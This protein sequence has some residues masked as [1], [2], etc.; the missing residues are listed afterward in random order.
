M[1]PS[2]PLLEVLSPPVDDFSPIT[3]GDPVLVDVF[4]A[5]RRRGE[6]LAGQLRGELN[7]D[8]LDV[9]EGPGDNACSITLLT[10][11]CCVAA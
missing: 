6:F 5:G 8:F 11:G 9:A 7:P 1:S 10:S 2:L 4:F 3:R